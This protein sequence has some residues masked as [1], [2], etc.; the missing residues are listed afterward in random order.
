MSTTQTDD[1][2]VSA[3]LAGQ[4]L[5]SADFEG[6]LSIRFRIAGV[7]KKTFE[8]KNGKPADTRRVL[9]LDPGGKQMSLNKTN[10]RL[11]VKWFGS[12]TRDWLGKEVA[13][14]R[15][16]SVSFAGQLV[17]GWRLRKPSKHDLAATTDDED[18][19]F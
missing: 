10:L 11:L 1:D 14:Y 9:V 5:N 4:A 16:E 3:E 8:A 17:G 2:D 6:G 13:V 12:K 15:D 7:D 19:P 18:A